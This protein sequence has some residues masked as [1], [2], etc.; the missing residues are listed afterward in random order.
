MLVVWLVIPNFLGV[1]VCV[2][3]CARVCYCIPIGLTVWCLS[4]LPVFAC[5]CACVLL[6]SHWPRCVWCVGA[7]PTFNTGSS[8][9]AGVS[10]R[11]V[12]ASAPWVA[13]ETFSSWEAMGAWTAEEDSRCSG[14]RTSFMGGGIY[15]RA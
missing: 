15:G 2:C 11:P 14:F 1:C 3:V 5:V 4:A 13:R 10:G 8:G 9:A 12:E 7:L 6:Y